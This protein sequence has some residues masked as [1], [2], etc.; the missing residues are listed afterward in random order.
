MADRDIEGTNNLNSL[1]TR[2]EVSLTSKQASGEATIEFTQPSICQ[3]CYKSKNTPESSSIACPKCD[4]SGEVKNSKQ[5]PFG[6]IELT[7][8]CKFCNGRGAVREEAC[9]NCGG[10]KRTYSETSLVV[11]MPP[12]IQ[13]GDTLRLKG[14]GVQ[15]PLPNK[16][17]GDMYV[18]IEIRTEN[19]SQDDNKYEAISSGREQIVS[20]ETVTSPP[21]K[22]LSYNDFVVDKSIG[23]GGQAQILRANTLIDSLD[24]VAVRRPNASGTFHQDVLEQF[25]LRMKSWKRIDTQERF[26]KRWDGYEHIVG[27][28]AIGNTDPWVA[29]EYMDGGTL[30]ELLEGYPN[31]LP[32]GM[33]LWFGECICRGLEIAHQLGRVHLDIKP[34]NILL[35][36]TSRWPW[37]KIADWGLSRIL[38]DDGGTMD[39]LTMEYAAP[40]QFDATEFGDPDQLTDIFQTG[41]TVYALLTGDPPT[42]IK[43]IKSMHTG[44]NRSQAPPS[45]RRPEIPQA[46]DAAVCLAL[47]REKVDRYDTITDF[48]KALHAIRTNKPLPRSVAA[49]FG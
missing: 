26:K 18:H 15:T 29:L 33:A 39:M 43:Q 10:E 12:N 24:R 4:G 17:N 32:I 48:R 25:F 13:D 20:P 16:P 38:A 30:E 46:V 36:E 8:E 7:N 19:A 31:G 44:D 2:T 45:E 35:K 9:P 28:I 3:S 34:E 23:T 11:E 40:E 14:Q 27:V 49:H 6:R 21:R 5:S 41:A 42:T 1:D 22:E 37:P 47:R